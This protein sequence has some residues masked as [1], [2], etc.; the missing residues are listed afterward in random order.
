MKTP[1]QTWLRSVLVTGLAYAVI[2]VVTAGLAQ[3]TSTAQGRIWRLCAWLL[4]LIAF[5]SHLAWER[6]RAGAPTLT[7]A[8]RVA[9]A[10]AL[11]AFALAAAGPARAHWS[12]N[13]FW[14]I[15][16]LSLALWPVLTGVPAFLAALVGG[17]ILGRLF[18]REKPL[19]L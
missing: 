15:A 7:A 10:V 12:A 6:L 13:D 3:S 18:E 4:S 14:R 19:D 1:A 2:G 5:A 16:V 11:G 17:S 8:R 9:G